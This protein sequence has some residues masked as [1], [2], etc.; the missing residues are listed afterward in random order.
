MEKNIALCI[1][2]I[3]TLSQANIITSINNGF[4]NEPTTWQGGNVPVSTDTVVIGNNTTVTIQFFGN[5]CQRLVVD[6]ILQ[7]DTTT[8]LV[9]Y[10]VIVKEDIIINGIVRPQDPNYFPESGGRRTRHRICHLHFER[11]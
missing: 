7:F 10:T 6:G 5:D 9:A 8:F 11:N 4:W 1:L 2:F 3:V